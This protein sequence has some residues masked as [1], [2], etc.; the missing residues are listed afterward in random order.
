MLYSQIEGSLFSALFFFWKGGNNLKLAKLDAYDYSLDEG[1]IRIRL[2]GTNDP[3]LVDI[4]S[5][6]NQAENRI[7]IE[8]LRFIYK[9]KHRI[10]NRGGI[11]TYVELEVSEMV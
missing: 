9:G 1:V 11:E 2:S 3:S 6:I 5:E 4:M 8:G 7:Y 10:F